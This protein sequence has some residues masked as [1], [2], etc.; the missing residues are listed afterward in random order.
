MTANY[1]KNRSPSS[2]ST[3][4]PWELFYG[5]K[6]DVSNMRVFGARTYVHVPK[7]LRYKLDPLSQAGTF[8]GYEPNSKAYRVLLEDGKM[9][10]SRNVTFDEIQPL[11]K[12]ALDREDFSDGSGSVEGASDISDQEDHDMEEEESSPQEAALEEASSQEAPSGDASTETFSQSSG[13]QAG[14]R[15]PS[16][17][18]DKPKEW[19]KVQAHRARA[20]EHEKPQSYEEALK[21]P[22]ASEWKL[23]MDE[24]IASLQANGTWDLEEQPVGVKTIPVKWV[25]KIKRDAS[26]NIERY[27]A[28]LVAKG[29]M[30]R[31]SID[32]N[33][34]FA[35]VSKHTT[36]RTLLALTTSED[37]EL[38]QLD[39]KNSLP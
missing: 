21:S 10:V 20:T 35:P 3:Q 37:L 12:E 27:K 5:R 31:E 25:F 36:L 7:Q 18:R 26:G 13:R 8:L 28:R 22:D 6:P 15:Y 1:L 11:I 34:V 4:T 16:R 33:E 14:S 19:F 24:E 9:V 29:F 17:Q 39:I 38:H 30:Q 2:S 32:Y 23:A